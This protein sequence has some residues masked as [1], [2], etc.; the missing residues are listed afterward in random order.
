ML[1]HLVHLHLKDILDLKEKHRQEIWKLEYRL[2]NML[3]EMRRHIDTSD[4]VLQRM[5]RTGV[6]IKS[7]TDTDTDTE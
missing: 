2:D 1:T 4:A 6:S 3:K 7:D 5:I